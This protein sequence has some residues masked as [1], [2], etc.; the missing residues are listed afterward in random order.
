L[1]LKFLVW[2]F[3]TFLPFY[4]DFGLQDIRMALMLFGNPGMMS[5]MLM[6]MPDRAISGDGE[7]VVLFF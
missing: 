6:V 3:G 5:S 2:H 1:A 7:F 4:G